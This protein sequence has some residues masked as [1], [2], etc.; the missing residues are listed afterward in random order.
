MGLK[1]GLRYFQLSSVLQGIFLDP[2]VDESC[3]II[4]DLSTYMKTRQ[5]QSPEKA[6]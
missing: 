5:R 1:D 3:F 2:K 6:R 4:V